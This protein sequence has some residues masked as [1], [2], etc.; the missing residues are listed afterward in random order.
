MNNYF[1]HKMEKLLSGGKAEIYKIVFDK[2][3]MRC[4]EKISN[5]KFMIWTK[6]WSVSDTLFQVVVTWVVILD[7]SFTLIY[8]LFLCSSH[9]IT[10]GMK[11]DPVFTFQLTGYTNALINSVTH[12]LEKKTK[13]AEFKN[14]WLIIKKSPYLF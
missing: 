5:Q 3:T 2:S 9:L 7:I 14:D 1:C 10:Q 6:D 4:C 11:S 8:S 12:E 13:K